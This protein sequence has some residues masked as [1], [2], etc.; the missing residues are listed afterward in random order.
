[1][2][3]EEILY[4]LSLIDKLTE[5]EFSTLESYKEVGKDIRGYTQNIR[6]ELLR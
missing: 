1:M 5:I 2:D 6:K 4:Q 3:K